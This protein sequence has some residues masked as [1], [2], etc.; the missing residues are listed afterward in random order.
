MRLKNKIHFFSSLIPTYYILR[1]G[2]FKKDA[3]PVLLYHDVTDNFYWSFSRVT[4]ELFRRQM[5]TLFKKGY[6]SVALDSVFKAESKGLFFSLTFDDGFKSLV[7]NALPVLIDHGFKASVFIVTDFMGKKSSWD[8]NIGGLYK[9]HMNWDDIFK[10]KDAGWCIGSHSHKHRDL[11]KISKTEAIDEINQSVTIMEKELGQKPMYFSYPFGRT[12]NEISKIV[13]NA[14][15]HA[16]FSSYPER[17][18]VIDRFAAGRRPVY[19]FDTSQDVIAR[20]DRST[21]KNLPYDIMGRSIN[22]FAGGV[23]LVKEKL[24]CR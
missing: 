12:N 4:P 7:N 16:A 3:I 24:N 1:K 11:T 19:L 9:S 10:L 22:F 8:V 6:E 13:E 15:F 18:D 21:W 17:N 14:G 2:F 5:R 20:V 23:G